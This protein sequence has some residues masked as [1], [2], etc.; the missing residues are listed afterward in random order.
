MD[1]KDLLQRICLATV[2]AMPAVTTVLAQNPTPVSQMEKLGRG[3]V[4]I[5]KQSG[6]FISWRLLGTEGDNVTF[7]LVR[8][9]QTIASDLKATN[10]TDAA[11]TV[12][13]TYQVVKKVD[14]KAVETSEEAKTW[15]TTY[16]SM[17]FE[18]PQGGSYYYPEK[19]ST[20]FYHYYAQEG[21]VADIDNDG[22]YELLIKWTP[23]NALDNSSSGFTGNVYYDCYHL[24]PSVGNEETPKRLWRIDLGKNI[25]SGSHY[26]MPM[27]FDFNGDGKAEL[28]CKTGPGSIDGQGHYVSEAADD[29]TIKNTDNTKDY[30][31][32]SGHILDGPEYLTVFD[33]QTGRAIHTIWYN[34]N[35]GFTTGRS[36]GYG[37]WGDDYGNRGERY[38]ACVAY[39]DGPD[40]NP[41]A[42]MCR[43]YYTQSYLWAVDFDGSK[44]R[45]KWLHGSVSKTRVEVTDSNGKK[46]VKT[47]NSN[48]SGIGDE[49]TAYGQGCHNI[50]VAD[51]DG[52]G[53]DEIIYG[54]ATIDNDG[55]LL[56]TTGLGHGDALHLS[57]FFPDR[58]GLQVM[59]P[60]EHAPYGWD[61]HDAATGEILL[62]R[63]SDGDNGRGM[64]GFISPDHRG[65]QFWSAAN[66]DVYDINDNVIASG[67]SARPAYC[68]RTYWDGDAYDELLDGRNMSILNNGK[69]TRIFSAPANSIKNGT[70]A[71][72]VLSADLFGDWREEV[73]Y[74]SSADSSTLYIC[75]TTT[76]T[77]L[78][79]PTLMHDHVY[80]MGV[81]WQNVA[82]NQPPH[83]GYYLPDSVAARFVPVEGQKEQTVEL[84]SDMQKVVCRLKN[85]TGAMFYQAYLDGKRISSF[86]AP[87]GFTFEQ[88]REEGT[89]S[90]S[91]TPQET[92]TY[93]FIINSSGSYDDVNISDT[94]RVNV[95][96]TS[97]I[98]SVENSGLIEKASMI[99]APDGRKVY[100]NPKTGIYIIRENGNPRKVIIRE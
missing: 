29:E 19:D 48:I 86:S 60:H 50:S 10:F 25:R 37:A 56:Y 15:E 76:E 71:Y 73:I 98:E 87:T 65:A 85:C 97:G 75:S 28:I 64:A 58:P 93:E 57:T 74:C 45:Q 95:V 94:I 77:K 20:D 82:Y 92:G 8:D 3:T 31:N 46:T 91:G 17:K 62:H 84:G 63:T 52:D 34:P 100:G 81:A 2:L 16:K 99:Y 61:V 4:A 68:F 11:G 55:Q 38:L 67:E 39:L 90:M 9:G 79:V 30:R 14:G 21:S 5:H 33:G 88:N 44:L 42:V 26:S 47:Y 35:R 49:Y 22:E 12:S 72:P 23:S 6:N 51:V 40:K 78:R 89:F 7:D 27:F 1:R 43:G 83:L 24:T 59:L 53:C 13:S 54:S 32:K 66:Y 41:S 80:R 69:S 18:R 36:S 96:N 70:K